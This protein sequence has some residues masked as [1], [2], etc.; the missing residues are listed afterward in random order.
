M[1]AANR[2]FVRHY[3]NGMK[4]KMSAIPKNKKLSARSEKVLENLKLCSLNTLKACSRM[5]ISEKLKSFSPKRY[6]ETPRAGEH[7]S[8]WLTCI[9]GKDALHKHY[10]TTNWP[11]FMCL[12]KD[13]IKRHFTANGAWCYEIQVFRMP[14]GKL[15]LNLKLPLKKDRMTFSHAT[16][17]EICM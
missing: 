3:R 10:V 2:Q 6:S 17:W 16:L 1:V 15:L 9:S 12:K 13:R 11:R 5:V 4:P 14:R 7:F 8:V